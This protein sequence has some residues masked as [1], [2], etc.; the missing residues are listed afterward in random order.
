MSASAR[1]G[2]TPLRCTPTKHLPRRV[3]VYPPDKIAVLDT[4]ITWAP[5]RESRHEKLTRR[6]LPGGSRAT[7]NAPVVGSQAGVAP[8]SRTNGRGSEGCLIPTP[9]AARNQ[10]IPPLRSNEGFLIP[11]P[12][13]ARNQAIPPLGTPRNNERQLEYRHPLLS[14]VGHK[15]ASLNRSASGSGLGHT[16]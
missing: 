10:A 14:G 2:S 15:I 8:P 13:E 7:R 6:G 9:V 1:K 4:D 16:P 11:S 5:R 3:S 12:V